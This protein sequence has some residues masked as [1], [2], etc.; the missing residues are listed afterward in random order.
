M[1]EEEL[2]SEIVKQFDLKYG[3]KLNALKELLSIPNLVPIL[4][5]P[6]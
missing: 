4:S 2:V 1:N 6:S 3:E 5:N